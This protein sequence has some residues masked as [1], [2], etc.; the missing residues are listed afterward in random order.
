MFV[1][2]LG[3]MLSIRGLVTTFNDSVR[4]VAIITGDEIRGA[5]DRMFPPGGTRASS[6]NPRR[7]LRRVTHKVLGVRRPSS[8]TAHGYEC[9]RRICRA[10]CAPDDPGRQLGEL[11]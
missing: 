6:A 10:L 4:V 11:T 9:S 5:I 8:C 1:V 2:A 7:A 3:L